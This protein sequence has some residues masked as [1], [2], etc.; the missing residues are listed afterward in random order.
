[1]QIKT[2]LTVSVSFWG[3]QYTCPDY[4]VAYNRYL[5][6][7]DESNGRELN[8]RTTNGQTYYV[9]A[10][11][12]N[13]YLCAVDTATVSKYV[14]GEAKFT[15]TTDELSLS[16]GIDVDYE[17]NIYICGY[18]SQN[19]HQLTKHGKLVR[20][21]PART[22]GL[23]SPWIIRFEINSNIFLLTDFDSGKVVLCK[24]C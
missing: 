9:H 3:L 12:K 20:I 19:I 16:R 23:Y 5:S 10:S 13:D 22:C 7:I 2:T 14:D 18:T 6:W 21:I 17:G 24:I 11:R 4:I 1:M 15:Y 8:R